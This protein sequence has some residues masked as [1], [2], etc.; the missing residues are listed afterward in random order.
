MFQAERLDFFMSI[1]FLFRGKAQLCE[2]TW[3]Q[4][5]MVED[6]DDF[7][8]GE[9]AEIIVNARAKGVTVEFTTKGIKMTHGKSEGSFKD[10]RGGVKQAEEFLEGIA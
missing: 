6:R 4:F 9:W 10:A 7:C 1:G 2:E 5:S 8:A 3:D